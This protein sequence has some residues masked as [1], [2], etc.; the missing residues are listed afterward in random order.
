MKLLCGVATIMSYRPDK[1]NEA[2]VEDIRR[3]LT[4]RRPSMR[5]RA[6]EKFFLAAL[7]SIPWVGGF[8]SAAASLKFEESGVR[9][10]DLQTQWLEGHHEK[11][12][13]LWNT[14]QE[15]ESRFENLGASIDERI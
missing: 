11:L 1:S 3:I 6:F 8:I 15:I 4:G 7:A 9:Q 14:L 2:A 5:R 13:Q 12:E 10:D